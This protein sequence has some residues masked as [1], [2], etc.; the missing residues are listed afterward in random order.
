[1]AEKKVSTSK[2]M[3]RLIHPIK[4]DKT[5]VYRFKKQMMDYEA[6][7]KI[8]KEIIFGIII[9]EL[10]KPFLFGIYI[11][12]FFVYGIEIPFP[13]PIIHIKI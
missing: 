2:A 7:L 3:A 1:M 11:I 9:A 4:T 10:I 13:I 5:D 12:K 6:A 8:A